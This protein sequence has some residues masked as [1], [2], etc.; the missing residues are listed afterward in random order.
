MTRRLASY[1]TLC[2]TLAAPLHAQQFDSTFSAALHWRMIGPFRGGRTVA[3]VG[4]PG[5]PS[6][7]YIGVNHGGAW[8]STDLGRT[9]NPIFDDQPTGSVG[10]IAV[11]PSDPNTIYI[12]S[13]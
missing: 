1:L 13:G 12:G 9:W 3:A 7:L 2:L 11:A 10:S 6:T 5:H 8:R 4:V